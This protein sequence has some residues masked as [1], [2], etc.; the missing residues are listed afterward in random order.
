MLFSSHAIAHEKRDICW[1]EVKSQVRLQMKKL[2]IVK[3]RSTN[4]SFKI[5]R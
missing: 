4:I 3:K 1:S 2:N 5:L